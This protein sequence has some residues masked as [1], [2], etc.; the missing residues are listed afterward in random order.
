M[1]P[2][3]LLLR[4][5]I[6]LS[7]ALALAACHHSPSSRGTSVLTLELAISQATTGAD[8]KINV[9]FLELTLRNTGA[10][11]LTVPASGL[12]ML[13]SIELVLQQASQRMTRGAGVG[14]PVPVTTQAMAPGT[15]MTQ[16]INPLGDGPRDVA[17]PPGTYQATVCVRAGTKPEFNRIHGGQ[18]SN[19]VQLTV[20]SV[21]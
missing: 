9:P 19:T 15:T 5:V 10:D 17:L 6:V 7:I 12:P 3:T 2:L 16:R 1:L 4:A 11:T 20:T 13:L 8:Y 14:D 18:C 21:Q